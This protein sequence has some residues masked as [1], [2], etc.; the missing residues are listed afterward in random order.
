MKEIKENFKKNNK[1]YN[2]KK[3]KYR[4]SKIK[5]DC[6]KKA[7]KL[8]EI[9]LLSNHRILIKKKVNYRCLNS[10]FLKMVRE[11]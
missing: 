5:K 8:P 11:S 2:K 7:N 6:D 9:R 10:D 4:K 3:E 1:R